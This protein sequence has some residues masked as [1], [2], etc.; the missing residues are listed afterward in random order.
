MLGAEAQDSSKASGAEPAQ[1]L[2]H[3][4]MLVAASGS[5]CGDSLSPVTW[6]NSD[7]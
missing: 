1:M 5:G 3:D 2:L 4:A 6:D 7:S